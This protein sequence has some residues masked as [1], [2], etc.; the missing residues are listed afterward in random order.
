[1]TFNE[2]FK[3]ILTGDEHQ[4][5]EAARNVRKFLYS[6]K[7]DRKNAFIQIKSI[8][9]NAPDTYAKIAEDWRQENFAMSVSVIYYLHDR[10]SQPDFLFPWLFQL[11]QHKNG[12]IHHA[13]VKMI[14]HEIGPLTYHI[15]FPGEKSSFHEFSPAQADTILHSL[16]HSLYGLSS[17]LW[18]PS[19]KKYKYIQSLPASPYKSVQMILADLE[20]SFE[21]EKSNNYYPSTMEFESKDE[22]LQKRKEV[23]Q[24]LVD[25]LKETGS[26]FT[27]QDVKDAIYHEEETDDFQKVLMMFDDGNPENLSNALELTNDAWNYFPHKILGGLSP[28]EKVLEYHK[29]SGK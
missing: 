7:S 5:R 23:E 6:R 14:G 27:L 8:I 28:A 20:D 13:A 29:K 10:E 25:M 9:N 21:P 1:M 22:I 2:L 12:N 3:A 17:V 4:S 11:L 19:F 15:R 24:E 18:Q 26:D 16:S